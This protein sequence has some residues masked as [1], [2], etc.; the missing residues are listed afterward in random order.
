MCVLDQCASVCVCVCVCVR[1]CARMCV[2]VVW[3]FLFV[4]WVFSNSSDLLYTHLCT[5]SVFLTFG[6]GCFY[7]KEGTGFFF[8][9]IKKQ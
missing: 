8:N 1:A 4:R 9:N 3:F 7:C 2:C 6:M 5:Q